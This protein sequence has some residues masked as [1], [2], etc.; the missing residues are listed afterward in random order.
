MANVPETSSVASLPGSL[1]NW[2][3]IS[4]PV[5][6]RSRNYTGA[7]RGG[8]ERPNPIRGHVPDCGRLDLLARAAAGFGID[9]VKP[10]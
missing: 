10:N 5:K 8:G 9:L 7:Y 6:M 2:H 3:Q 4:S 1:N